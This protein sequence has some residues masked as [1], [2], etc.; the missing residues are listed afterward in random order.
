MGKNKRG[1]DI[2]IL[3]ADSQCGTAET[4][5]HCKAIFL[6]LKKKAFL[7]KDQ[8]LM[9]TA[10][11]LLSRSITDLREKDIQNAGRNG[12]QELREKHSAGKQDTRCDC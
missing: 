11:T 10:I 9:C 2:C 6:K 5:E 3:M 1:G 7:N 4:A 12:H 8:E